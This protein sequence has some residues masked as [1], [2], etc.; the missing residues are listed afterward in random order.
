MGKS[1]E[2]KRVVVTGIGQVTPIG[3]GAE[4]SWRAALD[5]VS[6][7]DLIGTFDHHDFAVHF[8]CEVKGF[9]PGDWMDKRDVRRCDRFTHMAVASC[10]MAYEDAK[11]SADGL[12][13]NRCGVVFGSGIGGILSVEEQIIERYM[14]KGAGKISPFTIPLLMINC[15]PGQIAIEFGFQGINYAPVTACASASHSLGLAFRHLQLGE[16]DVMISGGSEAGISILGLG[17]FSNMKAL[18]TRND[19]PTTA[20]RPFDKER[21]GFVMGEGAGA[22]VLEEYE[23]AKRRGAP[24]YAEFLGCGM[25]DDA[26][27]IT[28]PEETGE[29]AA[30]AIKLAL[31]DGEVAPE[32]LDYINAHGTSTPYND[33]TETK[34]IKQALGEENARRVAVSSTKGCTGHLLGAAGAVELGFLAKAIATDTIPPT[35]NYTTPDP[36]CDL[37]YTPNRPAKR[38]I[39]HGLSN[40]LGFGGH[41]IALLLGKYAD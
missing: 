3:I 18:S 26:H 19:D 30:R 2:L 5:G 12:D 31:A 34:A 25:T 8:A 28:A 16:A 20:S 9:D 29:G 35:I 1:I 37:D 11:L 13:R 4:A 24:V 41:N 7:A 10:R 14:K 22:L 27:H 39:R 36:E 38:E 6:G 17:G 15:A 32:Q 40:S 23:H 21:D 33:K